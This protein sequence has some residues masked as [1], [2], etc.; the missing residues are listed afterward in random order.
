MLEDSGD[1]VI[2]TA[3][4]KL[5]TGRKWKVHEAMEAAKNSFE[6]REI[7]GHT[8]T[9]GQGLGSTKTEW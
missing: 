7:N 3:K 2:E 6:I 8:Q 9:N 1:K 4:P 5:K